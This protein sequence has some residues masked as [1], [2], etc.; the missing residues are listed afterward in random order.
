M[1]RNY[2]PLDRGFNHLVAVAGGVAVA[3]GDLVA[4]SGG[5]H[6]CGSNL[7]ARCC[8]NRKWGRRRVIR[9][10]GENGSRGS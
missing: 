6:R 7:Y 3:D 9:G 1:L 4:Y 8:S 10:S 5:H 2:C